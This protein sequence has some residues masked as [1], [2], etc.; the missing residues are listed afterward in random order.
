VIPLDLYLSG[1]SSDFGMGSDACRMP[2]SQPRN[3]LRRHMR[4]A[5]VTTSVAL[6]SVLITDIAFLRLG[7]LR[8]L[9]RWPMSDRSSGCN[10]MFSVLCG[11]VEG[12]D[13]PT[14]H[15]P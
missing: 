12:L 11:Y 10:K 4:V 9:R 1:T 14:T 2:K 8:S 3:S 6:S 13:V 15:I 5:A 7:G